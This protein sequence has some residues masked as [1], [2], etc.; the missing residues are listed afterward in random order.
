LTERF[1]VPGTEWSN[2][3]GD[4]LLPEPAA[5]LGTVPGDVDGY[6]Q[7]LGAVFLVAPTPKPANGRTSAD[8]S[9]ARVSG[10]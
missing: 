5:R 2:V 9:Q 8:R 7:E 6:I 4:G 1:T 3:H 10:A